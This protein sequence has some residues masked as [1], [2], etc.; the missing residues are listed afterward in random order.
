MSYTDLLPVRRGFDFD[1]E[2]NLRGVVRQQYVPESTLKQ[3]QWERER[4]SWK[5]QET[6]RI[7]SIPVALI[8][9]L[10]REGIDILNMPAKEIM[11]LLEQRGYGHYLAYGG[12]L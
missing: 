4:T 5:G 9:Q 1:A 2:G 3:L 7:A 11:V 12:S 8:E 10:Q 6:L